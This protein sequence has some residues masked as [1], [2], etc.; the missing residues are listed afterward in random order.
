VRSLTIVVAMVSMA[1]GAWQGNTR[2]Q[3]EE[4]RSD[5]QS[6]T[7]RQITLRGCVQKGQAPR[8]FFLVTR[9]PVNEPG[10]EPASPSVQTA[11]L[12]P[13]HDP[14]TGNGNG[15]GVNYELVSA[16]PEIDLA[17]VVGKRVEA[18]GIPERTAPGATADDSVTADDSPTAVASISDT[19]SAQSP[20]S[21]AEAQPDASSAPVG[22]RA[23]SRSRV[24]I[25][26]VRAIAGS[27]DE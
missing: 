17:T 5:A 8:S 21:A 12:E 20:T 6:A 16:K 10:L 19:T 27:C 14:K 15:P 23:S 18:R 3:S 4:P 25:T 7:P 13:A 1:A 2:A 9:E 26:E 24:R 11:P 22:T